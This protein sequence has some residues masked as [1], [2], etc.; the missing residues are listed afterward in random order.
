MKKQVRKR[1]D[2]NKTLLDNIDFNNIND[3]IKQIPEVIFIIIIIW[4]SYSICFNT[5]KNTIYQK[6][7][8]KSLIQ[9]RKYI[10]SFFPG[11]LANDKVFQLFDYDVLFIKTKEM[12][13]TLAL[14]FFIGAIFLLFF[15]ASGR[16]MFLFL[17]LFLDIAFIHNLIFYRKEGIFGIIKIVVYIIVLI[18][19]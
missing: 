15:S 10:D 7:L 16:K 12:I 2:K 17:C 14:L 8:K 13:T 6:Y 9:G 18:W 1:K 19:L 3:Y 11:F 4:E 5:D